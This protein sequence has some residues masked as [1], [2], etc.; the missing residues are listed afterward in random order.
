[1]RCK[2]V[3]LGRFEPSQLKLFA[4][5]E[6]AAVQERVSV[7]NRPW[8]NFSTIPLWGHFCASSLASEHVCCVWFV[9]EGVTNGKFF[10]R[11]IKS[12]EDGVNLLISGWET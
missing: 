2:K 4:N 9:R 1:M 6:M 3:Y 7:T 11:M 5:Q 8:F 10:N 12:W